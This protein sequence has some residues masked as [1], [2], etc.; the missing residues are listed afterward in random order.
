M[1]LYI[2]GNNTKGVC[3]IGVSSDVHSRL[4]QIQ[5]SC[6]YKVELLYY[7]DSLGYDTEKEYHRLY[8]SDRLHGE[9]FR[10]NKDLKSIIE[11]YKQ[12]SAQAEHKPKVIKVIPSIDEIDY[13]KLTKKKR[14]R[15]NKSKY[16]K[17]IYAHR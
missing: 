4:K 1:G 16:I 9:W 6:Y 14:Q 12:P 15:K 5:T 10:I 8:A 3:K 17:S 7:C 2:I 11:Q 13:Y